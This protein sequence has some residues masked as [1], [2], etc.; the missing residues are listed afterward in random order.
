MLIDVTAKAH[1]PVVGRA[2]EN[3]GP[4]SLLAVAEFFALLWKVRGYPR[5]TPASPGLQKGLILLGFPESALKWRRERN[6]DRTFSRYSIVRPRSW[7][8][9]VGL[10][11]APYSPPSGSKAAKRP[12]CTGGRPLA[13]KIRLAVG[14]PPVNYDHCHLPLTADH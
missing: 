8:D 13:S 11:G 3:I 1:V 12:F 7:A 2:S 6:W 5:A 14:R 4:I 10:R 9:W